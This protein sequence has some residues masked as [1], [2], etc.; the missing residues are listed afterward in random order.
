MSARMLRGFRRALARGIACAALLALGFPTL[1][2]A[3]LDPS[4]VL[5]ATDVDKTGGFRGVRF[6]TPLAEVKKTW[7]LEPLNEEPTPG[8][9]LSLFIRNEETKT[10]GL[11]ALQEVVYYFLDGKFYA[12]GLC[13]PDTRQ[14]EML[15][16][17]LDIAFGTRPQAS[18]TGDSRVWLG[19]TSS[20][21]LNVNP[22]TGEGRALIFDNDLQS[23]YQEF[24][25]ESAKKAASEF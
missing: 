14:S 18:R 23:S 5:Q 9:R 25:L 1:F 13:T 16:E 17:A 7:D 10:L 19:K 12:I 2:A 11:I 20:A 21:Q 3:D 15:R 8:D 6:G 4:T 22:A 24:F